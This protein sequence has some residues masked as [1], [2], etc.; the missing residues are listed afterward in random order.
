MTNIVLSKTMF[1][2]IFNK[3]EFN[4]CSLFNDCNRVSITTIVIVVYLMFH[5]VP[6]N[7]YDSSVCN[8]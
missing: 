8:N 1:F 5:G 4:Y 3:N 7:D 2:V 6:L